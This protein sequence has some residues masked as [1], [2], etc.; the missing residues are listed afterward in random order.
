MTEFTSLNGG[1]P[2]FKPGEREVLTDAILRALKRL[3]GEEHPPKPDPALSADLT[4]VLRAVSDVKW[5]VENLENKLL[6]IAAKIPS[7]EGGANGHA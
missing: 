1:T 3:R 6:D 7:H 5:A 4:E 2:L